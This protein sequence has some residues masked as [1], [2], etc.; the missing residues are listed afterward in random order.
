M[1]DWFSQCTRAIEN[2]CEFQKAVVDDLFDR[3]ERGPDPQK[4]TIETVTECCRNLYCGA[5]QNPERI[6]EHQF[7]YWQKQIT[8]CNNVLLKMVGEQVQPVARP[9][10]GDRRFLDDAWQENVLFD[11]IK[12]SYLLASENMYSIVDDMEG[13]DE[14]SQKRLKY[15]VRQMISAMA[16]T[17]FVMT[18]PEVLRKTYETKGENLLQGLQMMVEDKKKSAEIFNVCMS[19]PD[20]FELGKNIACAPG[21][22]VAQNELMQ[23]IQYSPTTPQV[24]RTPI[25]FIPSWVNKFYLIDLTEKVSFVKWLADQGHTVFMISWVNPDSA[26]RKTT[27]DDYMRLG[28]LAASEIIEQITGEKQVTGIGYCL[29]GMLL[30]SAMAYGESNNEQRFASATY[31]ATTI[32]FSDT[33]DIG[34]M[35][36]ERMIESMERRISRNGYLD[37]RELSAGFNL[38]RENELFWNYYVLNYLK[39]ERPAALDLMHW[40]SDNTNV[41]E[42]TYRTLLRELYLRNQLAAPTDFE[43]CGRR[44]ELRNIKTPTYVLAAEKDH[45]ALWQSCYPATQL[46]SGDVR[47]VLAGSGHIAGCMN[48]PSANKYH[49]YVN[50]ECPPTAAE[51]LDRAFKFEGSWWNDWNLWQKN[52]AGDSIPAREVDA[53]KAIEAAPGSYVRRRLDTVENSQKAA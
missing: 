11:F 38:L 31:M 30:A 4:S 2:I 15:Y 51:W 28:P 20:A 1:L 21:F 3:L 35:V 14:R 36:D 39:G 50:P 17:N 24:N 12:Q 46:Q 18:N 26:H 47:F 41:P 32:D 37:G 16:P 7:D 42:A 13:I 33:G 48:P 27:L 49:F 52:Y 45:I 25:L 29:G 34:L 23:L 43:L 19:R 22:V 40:N 53:S 10:V 44:I 8:L 6:I 5:T 9:A